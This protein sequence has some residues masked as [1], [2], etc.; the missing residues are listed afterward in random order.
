MRVVVWLGVFEVVCVVVF[1]ECSSFY[2]LM[3]VMVVVCVIG[4]GLCL[5]VG[6][7]CWCGM[8]V[9]FDVWSVY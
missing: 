7:Y 8:L 4:V 1:V 3:F 9:L 2:C 6:L 5:S